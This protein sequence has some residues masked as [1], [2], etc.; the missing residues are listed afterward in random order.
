MRKKRRD[1]PRS[2]RDP[3][4]INSP[5]ARSIRILSEY[6]HPQKIFSESSIKDAIVFFGSARINDTPEA[7]RK[8]RQGLPAGATAAEYENLER[9]KKL[10][11]YYREAARLAYRLTR[12]SKSLSKKS[13][14]FIVCSGGGPGIMEAANRGASLA[15]GISI[16]LNITL[17]FEQGANRY[18]TPELSFNFHYFFMRKYWFMTLAKA[19][20]VFPGGFGTM[21]ELFEVLTLVQTEKVT[22]QVPIVI[23]GKEYWDD[24]LNFESFKKWGLISPEDMD[25]FH[26]VDS[27]DEA[28]EF[29]VSRLTDL[30]LK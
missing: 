30:Y 26:I 21:D 16:G 25:L 11:L 24:I 8:L 10:F 3:D 18:I 20:V 17:P 22:R 23:Y 29:L 27:V 15:R 4:F 9:Q 14:R 13:R 1:E 5:E 19:L 28:E 12:W 7:R 6:Y 2:Y